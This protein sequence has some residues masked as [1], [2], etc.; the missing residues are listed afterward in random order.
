MELQR[1]SIQSVWDQWKGTGR[2]VEDT[3]SDI[4]TALDAV[5]WLT[6]ELTDPYLKDLNRKNA[7]DAARLATMQ[8]IRELIKTLEKPALYYWERYGESEVEQADEM[9][10]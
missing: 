5:E 8:S 6:E 7:I 4:N 9:K 10:Q 2:S 1:M 3:I